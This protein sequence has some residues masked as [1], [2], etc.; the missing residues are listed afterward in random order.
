LPVSF[1]SFVSIE[2]VTDQARGWLVT[3]AQGAVTLEEV[4]AHLDLEERNSDLG[5]PELID[6]RSATTN[7]TADQVR[8]LAHRAAD[9][10]SSV[11]LGP[12]AI[13]TD[14]DVVF[15]MSRMY[16][17]FAQRTGA[18]VEV[19]RDFDAASAWLEHNGHVNE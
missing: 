14:N 19:F 6:A 2:Y 3:T 12:T 11:R 8:R 15:G 17:V 18:A 1:E 9:M 7:V 16:S 10:L 13:V 5:R 4:D